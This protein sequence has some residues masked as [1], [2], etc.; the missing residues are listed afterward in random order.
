VRK[1]LKVTAN[2][3]DQPNGDLASS[4]SPDNDRRAHQRHLTIFRVAK[5]TSGNVESLCV[6]RNL[7]SSGMMIEVLAHYGVGRKVQVSLADEQYL[8]SQIV[9]QRDL[10]I[11][12]EFESEIDVSNVLAKP[13]IMR[14]GSMRR[15]PRMPI[16]EHAQ[17]H[18]GSRSLPIEICDISLH[19]VRIKTNHELGGHDRLWVVVN[20]LDPICGTLR[21]RFGEYAGIEFSSVVP[22]SR[23]M[24]WLRGYAALPDGEDA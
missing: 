24:Q 9:W 17:L 7:S 14:N 18:A 20:G 19:G 10:T 2:P 1:A 15:M 16:R 23:L 21:W 6:A 3:I 11:G 5:L 4:I 22:I 12:V 8:E 13:P